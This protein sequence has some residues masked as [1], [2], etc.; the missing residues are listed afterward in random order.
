[1][2]TG[3]IKTFNPKNPMKDF[4]YYSTP[5]S[6]CAPKEYY[7]TYFVYDNGEVIFIGSK[8]EFEAFKENSITTPTAVVQKVV[9]EEEYQKSINL[10]RDEMNA[11]E[12]EFIN[13]LFV[14][15]G[16]ENNP[17]RDKCY[18]IAYD[19]GHSH[20]FSDVFNYFSTLVDL[21]KE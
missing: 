7:T 10:F 8:S 12:N 4:S 15:F 13:D 19:M 11:L 20:G 18:G 3:I 14:E 6:R 17:K 21:I 9:D 2:I 1:M 5:Q 16:V